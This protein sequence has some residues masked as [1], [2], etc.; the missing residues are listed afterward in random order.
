MCSKV[1]IED[2]W[3]DQA[4]ASGPLDQD[5]AQQALFLIS[6]TSLVQEA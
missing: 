5:L 2:G 3:L 6:T 4:R 1:T